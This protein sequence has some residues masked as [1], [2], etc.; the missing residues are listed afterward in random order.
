MSTKRYVQLM[1]MQEAVNNL[2]QYYEEY[3]KTGVCGS[4]EPVPKGIAV[5]KIKCLQV[6]EKEISE[7]IDVLEEKMIVD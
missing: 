1:L 7:A 2:I 4:S 3:F 6:M 5:A